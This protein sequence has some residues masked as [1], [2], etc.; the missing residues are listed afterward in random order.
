[1]PRRSSHPYSLRRLSIRDDYTPKDTI[2]CGLLINAG[3]VQASGN[4]YV[5]DEKNVCN[6]GK[7]GG[8]FQG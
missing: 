7:G 2:A 5:G 8:T 6:F 4:T 1:V 3:G